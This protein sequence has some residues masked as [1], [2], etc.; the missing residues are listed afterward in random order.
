MSEFNVRTNVK[1]ISRTLTE[2]QR[3]QIPFATS[4]ALN[5]TAFLVR[6]AE[7]QNLKDVLES[8]TPF[9]LKGLRVEKSTKR[10]LEAIVYMADAQANYLA[11]FEATGPHFL[12]NKKALIVPYSVKVNAY[13]NI[14][15]TALKG[16]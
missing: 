4:V 16:I 8:P 6:D 13:G 9:T 12:G 1:E 10:S 2:I 11:P 5:R 7:L 14:P 3:R 15:R